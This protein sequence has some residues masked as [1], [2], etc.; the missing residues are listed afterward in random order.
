MLCGWA[1]DIA[2]GKNAAA[3]IAWRVHWV[4]VRGKFWGE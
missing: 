3:N 4:G 1:G 2:K